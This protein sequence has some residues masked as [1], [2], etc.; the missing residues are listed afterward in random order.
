MNIFRL[1]AVVFVILG[2]FSRISGQTNGIPHPYT[3]PGSIYRQNF[4]SL[5]ASG[6]FSF[7][8]KGPYWLD[9][10]P[11]NA[12]P[13]HGWQILQITGP[14]L[15][16]SP[17]TGS[18]T[19]NAIYSLGSS[20]ASDRALG[21]LSTSTGIY[22]FGV[23]LT[24]QTGQLLNKINIRFTAEQW[25]KG[26]SGNRNTWTF[27]YKTGNISSIDEPDLIT[28]STG[29]FYSPVTTTGAGA[30]NGNLPENQQTVSIQ[31]ENLLWK[32]GE[33]LLLRWNDA[34]ETGND[35]ALGID[36]FQFAA[37][38]TIPAPVI[39]QEN[40]ASL[41][42]TTATITCRINDPLALTHILAEFARDSLFSQP[43]QALTKPDTL[44]PGAVNSVI[45][46]QLTSLN[47]N[48]HY[49]ARFIA[50]NPSGSATSNLLSFQ[51][52]VSLPV[53]KTIV[54]DIFIHAANL[55]GRITATGGGNLLDKGILWSV[56]R[57][58]LINRIPIPINAD[59]FVTTV[60][61]LPSAS[62]LY[63]TAYVT[64]EGGTAYGDTVS[65]QIPG[66]V[67]SLSANL[68]KLT[69]DS[70][71]YFTLKLAGQ[72]SGFSP[73]NFSIFQ[74]NIHHAQITGIQ[75]MDSTYRIT[76]NTGSG[77]GR[78]SL[79]LVR[80]SGLS[81]PISNLPFYSA[82]TSQVDKTPVL[83]QKIILPATAA[84]IGDTLSLFIQIKPEPEPIAGLEGWIDSLPVFSFQRLS[85]SLYQAKCIIREGGRDFKTRDSI[86]VSIQLTDSAGNLSKNVFQIVSDSCSIDAH[87]PVITHLQHPKPGWYKSGDSLAWM[88]RFSEPVLI[89][90]N[91]PP[92]MTFTM[93]TRSRSAQYF[94]GN[95]T[96]S[97][98]LRYI[99]QSG[100]KDLDGINTGKG[101]VTTKPSVQ[102]FSGNPA[103]LNFI[104]LPSA[105]SIKIDAVEPVI[106]NLKVSKTG[107][108]FT[109]DSI[110]FQI[111]FS[112]KVFLRP[113][114]EKP[115][116]AIRIGNNLQ[117]ASYSS[118]TGTDIL[119]FRYRIQPN[120]TDTLGC[121]IISPLI[122][123]LFCIVDSLGNPIQPGLHNIGSTSGIQINPSTIQLLETLI[124]AAGIYRYGDVLSFAVRYN[125][126]A[127]ISGTTNL[128]SI[129]IRI[130]KNTRYATYTQGSGSPVLYFSYQI[131]KDDEDSSG[132]TISPFLILNSGGIKDNKGYFAPFL[133]SSGEWSTS[134]KVDAVFPEITDIRPPDAGQYRSG[135]SL[136][137]LLHFS[138]NI[139]LAASENSPRIKMTIGSN[140]R[141]LSYHSGAG[142]RQLKFCY[143]IINGDLDKKGIK[144]FPNIIAEKN[145]LTDA[146]G[147]PANLSFSPG[148][149]LPVI[150]IDGIAPVFGNDKPD[151][152]QLCENQPPYLITDLFTV[153]DEEAGELVSWRI[154]NKPALG[155]LSD[156]SVSLYSNG[157]KILPSGWFY[158][159]LAGRYGHDSLVTEITDGIYTSRK[160]IR[161]EIL[162]SIGNNHIRNAQNLCT[163]QKP[164]KLFGTQPTG[165]SGIYQYIWEST[166]E[167]DLT[168]F[169][170]VDKHNG[171]ADL[172]PSQLEGSTWFRRILIS[173]ACR[174]SSEPVKINLFKVGYW[175]GDSSQTWEDP[176][177]WC[178]SRIPADTNDVY[179]DSMRKYDPVI[180]S[181]VVCR[182]LIL[183]EK[184]HLSI[185]GNLQ[186]TG[187]I[188]ASENSIDA[189]NG[190]L[191]F[192]GTATQY[193]PGRIL[194]Q[195]QLKNAFIQT[196]GNVHLTDSLTITGTI[197]LQKGILYTHDFLTLSDSATLAPVATGSDIIGK[198]QL[199][200]R[201][202]E[203]KSVD[204]ILAHPFSHGI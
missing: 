46:A 12:N 186:I 191:S 96:D 137:M 9:K 26:G 97:L 132:I 78:L 102:D 183:T 81:A 131:Q 56:D 38:L 188:T 156:D 93:G 48:T 181:Q 87:I 118:G 85:D 16:F 164:E 166:Q 141:Y 100:D 25:R 101:L 86:P 64:N 2:C 98:L 199:K 72:V 160:T 107:K 24:N 99:I 169:Q 112:K 23:L 17:G 194:R 33:Q 14:K 201:I 27:F 152:I 3:T 75:P 197:Y 204:R 178:Q 88:I 69:R 144:I 51:T 15:N 55:G 175:K 89:D 203:G 4:D 82:D 73:S 174:D 62:I 134:I 114:V 18:S 22:A 133:I 153:T 11:I 135:D 122:D 198:T 35:D 116:L 158:Q 128:P 66:A 193:L 6:T 59:S 92:Q 196:T 127:F 185:E 176:T 167:T 40:V 61:G 74:N 109:G 67:L 200:I 129:K 148:S 126:A 110:G 108:Y 32:P 119:E 111:Q 45:E 65:F 136:V 192:R 179:I 149:S 168:H 44:E 58:H 60:T 121:K 70:V 47:P 19:G 50:S 161:I 138:E 91:D 155:I 8:G 146:A 106:Q 1:L 103:K 162:P 147:N 130:G 124:P 52:P 171:E 157:K 172:L 190:S 54:G 105:A 195:H 71:A 79:A 83:V 151:S 49:F 90:P 42:A 182:D 140:T 7:T 53:V 120:D 94:S 165:G 139:M 34:D 30:L 76:I 104:N 28:D 189:V 20:G 63:A 68:P 184:S 41:N 5:P 36:D 13:L 115:V 159:P 163:D 173:G 84:K 142:T 80:D 39:N 177:N 150:L 154:V 77:D 37:S 123:T 202:P 143:T 43:V 29:N 125:E 95:G 170:K 31:L 117:Y 113:S 57:G 21:S 10:A 145:Q 187:R 180:S